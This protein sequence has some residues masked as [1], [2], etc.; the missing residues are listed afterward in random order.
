VLHRKRRGLAASRLPS[1]PGRTDA[2]LA[3]VDERWAH[4]WVEAYGTAWREGD[5]AL[6][7]DLFTADAVYRS[8]P[9]RPPTV[10]SE[11]IRAY[12]RGS[13]ATQSD[14]DLRFGEPLVRGNRVVVEWW[15]QMNDEGRPMTL[16]GCL[17]LRFRAGGRCEELREYWHIE[18]GRREPPEGW[19]R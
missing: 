3:P 15:A 1:G 16:P 8:S 14:L 2:S 17:V 9:F 11:A 6:V 13:T 5:D 10:G 19:G 4:D 12:W 18:E 7:A